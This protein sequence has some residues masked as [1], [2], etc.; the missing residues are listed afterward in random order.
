MAPARKA[1][2]T[3]PKPSTLNFGSKSGAGTSKT[4]PLSHVSILVG[5]DKGKNKQV[6][7]VTAGDDRLWVERYRPDTRVRVLPLVRYL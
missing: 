6:A 5:V 2:R 1:S 4:K 7:S 3:K